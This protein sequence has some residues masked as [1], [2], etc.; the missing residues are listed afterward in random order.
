MNFWVKSIKKNEKSYFF[1]VKFFNYF[2]KISQ[3]SFQ[4]EFEF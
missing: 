2:H 4:F 1:N 3:K